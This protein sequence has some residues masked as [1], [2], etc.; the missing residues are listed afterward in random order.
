MAVCHHHLR[1]FSEGPAHRW[2]REQCAPGRLGWAS[3]ELSFYASLLYFLREPVP[4]DPSQVSLRM[5][6]GRGP[7]ENWV[8]LLL[9]TSGFFPTLLSPESVFLALPCG[10]RRLCLGSLRA[11]HQ[12][13]RRGC[14][15]SAR[16]SWLLTHA[17]LGC[18]V[19]S[20]LTW[21]SGPGCGQA[22]RSQG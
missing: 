20:A 3:V 7:Q 17:C 4:V 6:W 10:Y 8:T 1:A 13:R 14:G 22:A 11:L 12:G 5:S 2:G 21:E 18:R 15:S 16:Q 9:L 19:L